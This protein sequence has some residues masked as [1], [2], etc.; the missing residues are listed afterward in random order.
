MILS[1]T[2]YIYAGSPGDTDHKPWGA[3]R[4]MLDTLTEFKMT[5][6]MPVENPSR[7][8]GRQY[9]RKSQSLKKR[10]KAFYPQFFHNSSW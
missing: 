10:Q 9:T 4:E 1:F 7:A 5:G 8:G 6:E 3:G 2:E